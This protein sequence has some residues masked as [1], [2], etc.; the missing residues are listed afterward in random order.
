MKR[1]WIAWMVIV[2]AALSL[3]WL[4]RVHSAAPLAVGPANVPEHGLQTTELQALV[5]EVQDLRRRVAAL[6]ARPHGT[7]RV[8]SIRGKYQF[9]DSLGDV[10]ALTAQNLLGHYVLNAESSTSVNLGTVL[11]ETL[12]IVDLLES[13][14]VELA[15]VFL[16]EETETDFVLTLPDASRVQLVHRFARTPEVALDL[17][18]ALSHGGNRFTLINASGSRTVF[19]RMP[20]LATSLIMG[21][22]E[23]R[24]T[25][26]TTFYDGH[27]ETADFPVVASMGPVFL[28]LTE[29]E[30]EGMVFERLSTLVI[31]E[32]SKEG[33]LTLFD[34]GNVIS[35]FFDHRFDTA[36]FH[37]RKMIM[38]NIDR[39]G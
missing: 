4:G 7:S 25:F 3:M 2:S 29:E 8:E 9:T 15:A 6:E 35:A 13:E 33:Q 18:A 34:A 12:A 21:I 22:E 38:A 20:R 37:F 14:E 26:T 28:I 10:N 27:T 16:T 30:F 31:L 39:Q 5:A 17:G 19:E 1:P 32:W 23:T 24:L 11:G 36:R